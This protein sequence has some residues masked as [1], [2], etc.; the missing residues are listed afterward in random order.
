MRV[1]EV[2]VH[3]QWCPFDLAA[4]AAAL[5]V[6]QTVLLELFVLFWHAA[7]HMNNEHGL[8]LLWDA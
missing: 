8:S 3:G 7:R 1:V 2:R 6:V 5:C 4:V